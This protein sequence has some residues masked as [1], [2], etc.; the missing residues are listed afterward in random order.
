[1]QPELGG[2]ILAGAPSRQILY[3]GA[4]TAGSR[5][6]LRRGRPAFRRGWQIERRRWENIIQRDH[7]LLRQLV[8]GF[9]RATDARERA[10]LLHLAMEFQEV[11]ARFERG[12]NAIPELEPDRLELDQLGEQVARQEPNTPTWRAAAGAW[13][14]Q[15]KVLIEREDRVRSHGAGLEPPSDAAWPPDMLE[16][17][18]SLI[19]QAMEALQG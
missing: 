2:T 6:T 9:E 11:H 13:T 10:L 8:A 1:M 14:A 16:C 3:G 19:A 4:K 18:L 5:G 15:L 7:E 12:C 17:R